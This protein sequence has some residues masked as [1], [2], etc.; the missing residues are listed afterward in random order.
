V[1]TRLATKWTE[2]I[3]DPKAKEDFELVL[4]NSTIAIQRILEIIEDKER[5]ALVQTYED[6]DCPSW[7]HK[8]ADNNGYRRA[9]REMKALLQFIRNKE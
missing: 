6:Y 2:N 9:C 1:G 5:A 3:R 7:S 8:A 4:R